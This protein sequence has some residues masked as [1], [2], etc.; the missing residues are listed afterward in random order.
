M[1]PLELM[2]GPKIGV[3]GSWSEL[4]IPS[5]LR[6]V[7]TVGIERLTDTER[8]GHTVPWHRWYK[9]GGDMGSKAIALVLREHYAQVTWAIFFSR[10]DIAKGN[11]ERLRSRS[12][13]TS[14]WNKVGTGGS[15]SPI[16]S[17]NTPALDLRDARQPERATVD[18]EN[19]ASEVDGGSAA[20]GGGLVDKAVVVA[21][22]EISRD[23]MTVGGLG[24]MGEPMGLSGGVI[25]S[26]SAFRAQLGVPWVD[27][28]CGA[29][30]MNDY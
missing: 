21:R 18:E 26:A 30:C 5:V 24:A 1:G 2:D 8:Q 10:R 6:L 7:D 15:A 11:L 27:G 17:A 12:G 3:L 13:A 23:D 22:T 14:G 29:R 28:A 9:N 4:P 20:G 19:E 16:P 25:A